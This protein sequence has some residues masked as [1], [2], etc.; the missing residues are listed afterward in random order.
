[1]PGNLEA[2]LDSA[3]AEMEGQDNNH[4]NHNSNRSSNRNSNHTLV[5][6][7]QLLVQAHSAAQSAHQ[8]LQDLPA[9][10]HNNQLFAAHLMAM[11]SHCQAMAAH[12]QLIAQCRLQPPRPVRSQDSTRNILARNLQQHWATRV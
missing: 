8:H 5:E 11:Q 1:M 4:N 12:Q 9:Q 2:I 10:S 7:G 3:V 6:A